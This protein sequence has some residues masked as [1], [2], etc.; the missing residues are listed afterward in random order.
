VPVERIEGAILII[1]G[2]RVMLDADLAAIYGVTTR[3]LK[4]QVRRNRDRFPAGFVFELTPEE[5]AELVANCDQFAR[6]KHSL[7]MPYAFT[8]HGA[9][10]LAAVLKSKRAVEVSVFVV[11]AF[12]RMHRMLADQ[13]QFALKLAEVESKLVAHD[14]SIKA[15]FDAIRQLMQKPKAEPEKLKQQ[16]G[17][18]VREPMAK[19]SA[20][21]KRR[22]T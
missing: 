7:R 6:L 20:G 13:R 19:Y 14:Q 8:E 12:I 21:A 15:V 18:H 2:E 10:M 11:K 16:I 17:F 4:E 5:K 3:R 9:V 22:R 1:R